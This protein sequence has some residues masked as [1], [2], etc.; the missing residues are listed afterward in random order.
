MKKLLVGL[1]TGATILSAGAY[2]VNG[3]IVGKI[4][5]TDIVAY[6]ND[7]EVTSYNIGGKTAVVIEDLECTGAD[8]KAVRYG[9][10]YSYNDEERLLTVTT[11]GYGGYGDFK[12]KRGVPGQ[13]VGNIYKT[14]IKVV[15]NGKEIKGYNIGGKTAVCIEDLGTVFENGANA[16]Y[17]YS[18]YLCRFVWNNDTRTVKLYTYQ[19]DD[20]DDF[21]DYPVR[22]LN[23]AYTDNMLSC[24]FDQMNRY[25]SGVA[26]V[27]FSEEF[28][29]EKYK[30]KDIYMTDSKGERLCIG[31]MYTNGEYI[32]CSRLN[33]NFKKVTEN[34]AEVL[35]YDEA[36]NYI[37]DNFE[38][39]NH[40]KLK[41]GDVFLAKNT[42]RI[43][44]I[45]AMKN[46]GFIPEFSF[47]LTKTINVIDNGDG[48][49]DIT[50]Y[51][52]AGPH[53]TTTCTMRVE[54]GWY[55]LFKHDG[56]GI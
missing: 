44:V 19:D 53:G 49:I 51:P 8:D 18:D 41:L 43:Y 4:Y 5:S 9:I 14:D 7:R 12:A 23:F 34:V 36:V 56:G 1:L 42:E 47:E 6:I 54:L 16:K 25:N 38:V 31:D 48:S 13:I 50:E 30:I 40:A 55:D 3:D 26:E 24:S 35:T 27:N 29:T 46:G 15:F 33:E 17:G 10:D 28:K 52:F 22:K 21:R 45:F 2:A 39:I 20:Y 32:V 11:N 37:N